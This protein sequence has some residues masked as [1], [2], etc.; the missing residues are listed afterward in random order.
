MNLQ[1]LKAIIDKYGNIPLIDLY[2]ILLTEKSRKCS[3]EHNK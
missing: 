1:E 2:E 3:N